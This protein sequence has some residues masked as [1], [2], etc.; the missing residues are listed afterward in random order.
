MVTFTATTGTDNPT[1][2]TGADIV[3]VTTTGLIQAADTF[4]GG[5]GIGTILIGTK[6]ATVNIDLSLASSNGT[7]GF[8]NFEALAFGN[9]GNGGQSAT[10]TFSSAQFGTGKISNS[11][12]VSGTTG[13]NAVQSIIV[14]VAS[15]TGFSAAGWTFTNWSTNNSVDTITINGAAGNETIAGSSRADAINAGDGAD[16]ISAL[17]GNDTVNAGAGDDQIWSGRGNDVIDGGTGTDTVH[18]TTSIAP[19]TVTFNTATTATATNGTF[20][21]TL[22]NVEGFTL[23]SGSDTFNGGDGD[24]IV[25]GGADWF[26]SLAAYAEDGVDLIDGGTGTDTILLAAAASRTIAH[27]DIAGWTNVEIIDGSAVTKATIQGSTAADVIDLSAF[28]QLINVSLNGG[29]GNDTITGTAGGETI[30][31]GAGVDSLTGNGG[32]DTFVFSHAGHSSRLAADTIT[33][34]GSDDTIDLS[35]IDANTLVAGDQGFTWIGTDDF[36]KTAGELRFDATLGAILGDTTG[37][38]V[39]NLQIFIPGYTPDGTEFVL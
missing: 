33:D 19:V 18:Y 3:E 15:G 6:N 20:T 22:S 39:A 5:D 9:T 17:D 2:S 13:Q 10:V 16:F 31:G 8:L 27:T 4:Q 21:D 12:A 11:L 32:A 28:S 25:N 36:S 23:S 26:K 24:D 30:N 37:N 29:A 7:A 35:A 34:M 38:G 1:F 14:N